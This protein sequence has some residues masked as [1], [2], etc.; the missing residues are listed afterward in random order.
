MFVDQIDMFVDQIDMLVRY[1]FIYITVNRFL[2][3]HF[4][5]KFVSYALNS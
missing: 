4:N 3:L 1:F 2:V 5:T